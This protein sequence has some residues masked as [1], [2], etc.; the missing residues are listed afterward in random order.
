LEKRFFY[1]NCANTRH[2]QNNVNTLSS[3]RKS[4]LG[5]GGFLHEI[6]IDFLVCKWYTNFMEFVIRKPLHDNSE[7]RNQFYSLL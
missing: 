3:F 6:D 7:K 4:R 1:A 5:K 2:E